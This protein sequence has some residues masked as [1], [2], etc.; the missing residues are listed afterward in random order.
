MPHP[1]K[2]FIVDDNHD[3]ADTLGMYFENKGF[4]VRVVY[5]GDDAIREVDEFHPEV[6]LLDIGLPGKDG[7]EIAQHIRAGDDSDIMLIA[8]SGYAAAEDVARAKDAGFDCHF[9]KPANPALL[10]SKIEGR[11]ADGRRC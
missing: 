3:A 8:V 2:I 5:D 10:L 11:L 1:H 7:Y 4:E 9:G 6:A